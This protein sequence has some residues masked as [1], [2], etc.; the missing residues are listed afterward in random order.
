MRWRCRESHSTRNGLTFF[1]W[2]ASLGA[3]GYWIWFFVVF[4]FLEKKID[5]F[6]DL[7]FWKER[8][9]CVNNKGKNPSASGE[10]HEQSPSLWLCLGPLK[11][12]RSRFPWDHPPNPMRWTHFDSRN[13]P[14]D[15]IRMS[16]ETMIKLRMANSLE[17]LI[18]KQTGHFR[19][20]LLP[21]NFWWIHWIATKHI[22]S[23]QLAN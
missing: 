13:Q 3:F 5:R 12:T 17:K 6:G 10:F 23:L 16:W 7:S 18:E 20:D 8:T 15:S 21:T 22:E 2:L 9:N 11:S 1:F 4:R 14:V 19:N